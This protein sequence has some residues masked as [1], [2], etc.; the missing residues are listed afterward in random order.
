MPEAWHKDHQ[1]R[2]GCIM[3]P[4]GR[5]LWGAETVSRREV[6]ARDGRCSE[7]VKAPV[8]GLGGEQGSRPQADAG[9][10]VQERLQGGGSKR[11]QQSVEPWR[12]GLPQ[13]GGSAPALC[14]TEAGPEW[15]RAS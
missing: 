6:Q 2:L 13:G 14:V 1:L 3:S 8:G 5:P 15:Q 7:N 9:R 12:R 11:E 4:G 10:S